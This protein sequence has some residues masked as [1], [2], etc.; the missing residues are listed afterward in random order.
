MIIS[1]IPYFGREK[2]QS[3]GAAVFSPILPE[4]WSVCVSFP[5]DTSGSPCHGHS[6]GAQSPP[7]Q[8]N[9][10][11]LFLLLRNIFEECA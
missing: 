2:R 3:P 11:D 7:G 6:D 8:G 1:F 10:M 5:A 9:P 4:K